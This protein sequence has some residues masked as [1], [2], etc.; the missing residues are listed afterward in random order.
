MNSKS[1]RNSNANVGPSGHNFYNL[2]L[3]LFSLVPIKN[4]NIH[5]AQV[6]MPIFNSC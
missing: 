4:E 3:K 6:L 2:L 5:N 1:S